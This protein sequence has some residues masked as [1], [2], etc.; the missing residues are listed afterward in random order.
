MNHAELF[1]YLLS[2]KTLINRICKTIKIENGVLIETYPTGE[3]WKVDDF[4]LNDDWKLHE[5][6]QCQK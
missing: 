6:T 3:H 4:N 5:E 1:S 2:G